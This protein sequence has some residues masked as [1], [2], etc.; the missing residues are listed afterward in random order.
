MRW[1]YVNVI[2]N[3][4]DANETTIDLT[5]RGLGLDI[6]GKWSYTR[7]CTGPISVMFGGIVG[8]QQTRNIDPMFR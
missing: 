8:V 5:N 6:S 7:F 1:W 3:V 4:A 2:E